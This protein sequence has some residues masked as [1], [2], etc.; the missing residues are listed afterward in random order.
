M[1]RVAMRGKRTENDDKDNEDNEDDDDA[2]GDYGKTSECVPV[3]SSTL[4]ELKSVVAVAS[5]H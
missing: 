2:A 3:L 1:Q 4:Y 5:K